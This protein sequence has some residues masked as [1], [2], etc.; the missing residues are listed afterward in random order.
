MGRFATEK[1]VRTARKPHQCMY[2]LKTIQPGEKYWTWTWHDDDSGF[3]RC[4]CH[5]MCSRFMESWCK[6]AC[7]SSGCD[8]Y[9][10]TCFQE[11][12]IDR[13]CASCD[14]RRTPACKGVYRCGKVNN[15][16]KEYSNDPEEGN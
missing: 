12:A 1:V 16:I 4:T 6:D 3:G 15:T 9:T 13:C 8:G 14:R 5:P 10:E 11:A 7:P 2:C